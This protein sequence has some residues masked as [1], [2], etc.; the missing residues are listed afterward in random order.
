ML[1]ILVFTRKVKENKLGFGLVLPHTVGLKPLQPN[2]H[3]LRDFSSAPTVVNIICKNICL[4]PYFVRNQ[5][6]ILR[7]IE[8]LVS[9]K[10]QSTDILKKS[11]KR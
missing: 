5:S 8:L 2:C 11:M 1:A 7:Y 9:D 3:S 4:P 10:E 6:E